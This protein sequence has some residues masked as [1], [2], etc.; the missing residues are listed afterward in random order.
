MR[1]KQETVEKIKNENV[2]KNII[3]T[4]A[5][6]ILFLVV[7]LISVGVALYVMIIQKSV[8]K[9]D[10]YVE[11]Y[12]YNAQAKLYENVHDMALPEGIPMSVNVKI[13]PVDELITDIKGYISDAMQGNVYEYNTMGI[14]IRLENNLSKY[15][16]DNKVK[17]DDEQRSNFEKYKEDVCKMYVDNV[18][19]SYLDYYATHKGTIEKYL[20]LA[21]GLGLLMTGLSLFL[22]F[23]LQ[24]WAHKFMKCITYVLA[25]VALV[26]I[27]VPTII[28]IRQT[29]VNIMVEPE[30]F[31][32][33][34]VASIRLSLKACIYA[35]LIWSM[36]T[37]L[38]IMMYS[39]LKVRRVDI[40]KSVS[41]DMLVEDNKSENKE[42]VSS[43]EVV[44]D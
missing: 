26:C 14:K 25:A 2:S 31:S 30:Y 41:K 6:F 16:K 37:I 24:E 17:I 21:L 36:C 1:K 27:V 4:A 7:T 12:S 33:V 42:D 40:S 18:K 10:N 5:A 34:I 13:F 43:D 8:L 19:I 35:G 29:Y 22:I 23:K 44:T 11:K 39:Q 20:F 38:C 28:L 9:S 32:E 3:T 15:L